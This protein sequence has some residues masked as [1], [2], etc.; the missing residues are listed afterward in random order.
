MKRSISLALVIAAIGATISCG[1]DDSEVSPEIQFT[2]DFTSGTEGWTGDFADYPNDEGVEEFYELDFTHS[3]L[4]EPLE[5]NLGSLKQSGSNRSDDLFMFVKKQVTGLE[6]NQ[7]YAVTIRIEIATDAASG[8]VG[9][10]GAPGES[11]YLKAGATA[12]EPRKVLD[13]TDNHF[14][15]NIDKGNQ[16]QDGDDMKNIGDFANGTD[17]FTY[18]LKTLE[19]N[20]PLLATADSNGEL[21]VTVGT[22]SGFEGITTIYYNTIEVSIN[23][24]IQ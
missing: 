21:W 9:I 1:D 14:R 5:T 22:D 20:I 15:M 4:P 8:A 12:I 16:S 23:A 13:D 7:D 18:V 24:I 19:T 2:Y 6:P 3:T 17:E 11:V 10:G